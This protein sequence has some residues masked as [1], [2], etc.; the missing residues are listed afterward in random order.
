M[1]EKSMTMIPEKSDTEVQKVVLMWF[2]SNIWRPPKYS[3]SKTLTLVI[4]G[5]LLLHYAMI[6]KDILIPQSPEVQIHKVE[7]TSLLETK[8]IIDLDTCLTDFELQC[9]L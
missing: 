3:A 6:Y 1:K 9:G 4:E 2:L 7:L 5:C 8:H